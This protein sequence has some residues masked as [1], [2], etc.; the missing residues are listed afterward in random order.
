[1]QERTLYSEAEGLPWFCDI[2]DS[3]ALSPQNNNSSS[4]YNQLSEL[5]SLPNLLPKQ[6]FLQLSVVHHQMYCVSTLYWKEK[7]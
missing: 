7:E 2:S 5:R 4:V 3:N 1:M 6:I